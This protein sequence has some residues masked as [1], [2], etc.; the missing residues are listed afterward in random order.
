MRRRNRRW[1]CAWARGASSKAGCRPMPRACKARLARTGAADRAQLLSTDPRYGV[2]TTEY[3]RSQGGYGVTLECGQ[4]D[5][6][7]AP[8]VA[9]RA[10]RNTLAHLQTDRRAGAASRSPHPQLLR[11]TA[12]DRQA[13]MPTTASAAPGRATT[14]SRKA[15]TIGLRH[16]GTPVLADADG[17]IVFPN[18][19]RAGRQRVVLFR[20]DQQRAW[21]LSADAGPTG[22][23]PPARPSAHPAAGATGGADSRTAR[24]SAVKPGQAPTPAL[25]SVDAA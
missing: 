20:A 15:S 10:I 2:G 3:M 14:R 5:D 13:T 23:R 25:C 17:F 6:P 8:E 7:A 21:A 9:W 22:V 11:L 19:R 1:P 24:K 12:G 4:H 18:A 16:D